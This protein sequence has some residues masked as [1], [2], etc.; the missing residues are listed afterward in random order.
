MS[1]VIRIHSNQSIRINPFN[2]PILESI[3][4]HSNQF[5]RM[6]RKIRQCEIFLREIFLRGPLLHSAVLQGK[7]VRAEAHERDV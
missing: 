1:S 2:H 4:I 7:N 6:R 3:R 5:Q